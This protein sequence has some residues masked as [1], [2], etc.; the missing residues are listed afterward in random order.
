MSSIDNIAPLLRLDALF[1]IDNTPVPWHC[2]IATTE[3]LHFRFLQLVQ[4]TLALEINASILID[5]G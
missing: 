5:A 3:L 4:K 2:C 1:S